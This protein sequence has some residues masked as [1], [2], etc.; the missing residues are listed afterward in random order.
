MDFNDI[1]TDELIEIY[2]KIDEFIKFLEKEKQESKKLEKQEVIMSKK[3]E[4]IMDKIVAN[5]EVLS[6]MPKNNLK[7]INIYQEKLEELEEEYKKYQK[8]R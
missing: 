7:N 4:D 5:K 3:I 8:N 2:K 6:T 1:K